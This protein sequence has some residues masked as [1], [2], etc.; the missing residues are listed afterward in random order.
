MNAKAD[1][2][3]R[4]TCLA[5][6][7]I[8]TTAVADGPVALGPLQEFMDKK[9]PCYVWAVGVEE[10]GAGIT[11]GTV[12]CIF[13]GVKDE[14]TVDERGGCM[15]GR[16]DVTTGDYDISLFDGTLWTRAKCAPSIVRFFFEDEQAQN[17]VIQVL[18]STV[19]MS[20]IRIGGVT[21]AVKPFGRVLCKNVRNATGVLGLGLPCD[22]YAEEPSAKAGKKDTK[23]VANKRDPR[24]PTTAR[25]TNDEQVGTPDEEPKV[26][27][28]KRPQPT[29]A[30]APVPKG[31]TSESRKPLAPPTPT[32][33]EAKAE[34]D[35]L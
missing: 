24:Q 11:T 20:K 14:G 18:G 13:D 9:K 17:Q 32:K 8:A 31:S 29:N 35:A 19:G 2:A 22:E 23:A 16:F 1:G 30:A 25:P 5:A 28:D 10:I 4:I 12:F 3:R 7:L 34:D 33:P 6:T 21:K 15:V 26:A 27:A